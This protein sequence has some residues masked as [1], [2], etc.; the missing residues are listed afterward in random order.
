MMK[1]RTRCAVIL[2]ILIV[3]IFVIVPQTCYQ[4]SG[5]EVVCLINGPQIVDEKHGTTTLEIGNSVQVTEVKKFKSYNFQLVKE[6]EKRELF[7]RRK[8]ELMFKLDRRK[9]RVFDK[10]I[11][12]DESFPP[13]A[14]EITKLKMYFNISERRIMY[15]NAE[16]LKT[17]KTLC[18][19]TP[20]LIVLIPSIPANEKIRKAIRSTYGMI[21]HCGRSDLRNYRTENPVKIAFLLGRSP[22]QT[23]ESLVRQEFEQYGDIVQTDFTDSYY[24]LTLKLLY[25]FKWVDTFCKGVKYVMKADEDVF[26]NIK[27]L[28]TELKTYRESNKGSVFGF[29]HTSSLSLRVL[30]TGKWGVSRAE[31]P[32]R[33]YPPY[34]QG[35]SYTLTGDLIPKIIQIA[36]HLPYLH[37]EDAFITGVIAGKILGA[38]LEHMIGNSYWTYQTPDPCEFVKTERVSQTNMNPELMF[39]TWQALMSPEQK[40]VNTTYRPRVHRYNL[41][42][43]HR[44][45]FF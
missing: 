10:T 7:E 41:H 2:I 43:S 25:G 26:V 11:D 44:H 20:E 6:L 3:F 16:F 32:L 38:R 36:E 17:T 4:N 45:N 23:V 35:T 33:K 1:L 22:N 31:Y 15:F 29:I 19:E 8:A 14:E 21:A 30:R 28:I 40:C 18:A 12:I 42:L 13:T 24:N 9:A 34:A 39:K 5:R 37:I 27:I